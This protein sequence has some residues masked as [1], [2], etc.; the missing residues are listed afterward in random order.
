VGV[1]DDMGL[2]GSTHDR[3]ALQRV[4]TFSP[5]PGARTQ[6]ARGVPRQQC[7]PSPSPLGLGLG[8]GAPSLSDVGQGGADTVEWEGSSHQRF[9]GKRQRAPAPSPSPLRPTRLQAG[10][11]TRS[12]FS[13]T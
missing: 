6:L 12:L 4:Y 8:L 9:G 13:S 7:V 10:A 2:P 11:D 5:D 3:E 1:S